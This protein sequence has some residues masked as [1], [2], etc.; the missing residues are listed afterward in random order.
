M[1]P[2]S[3]L[4]VT[5]AALIF[6][7]SVLAERHPASNGNATQQVVVVANIVGGGPLDLDQIQKYRSLLGDYPQNPKPVPSA[8]A[9]GCNG[10]A[11]ATGHV[12][13]QMYKWADVL[14]GLLPATPEALCSERCLSCAPGCDPICCTVSETSSSSSPCMAEGKTPKQGSETSPGNAPFGPPPPLPL[15]GCPCHCEASCPA[16]IQAI[17][18]VTPGSGAGKPAPDDGG[19]DGGNSTSPAKVQPPEQI[20]PNPADDQGS[21]PDSPQPL[22]L[23]GCPCHCEASCPANIQ[24]ICCVTPG[25]GAAKPAPDDGSSGSTPPASQADAQV[26]AEPP[27][28]TSLTPANHGTSSGATSGAGTGHDLFGLPQPLLGCPCHCEASCPPNIQAICCVTPGSGVAKPGPDP[29]DGN[30]DNNNKNSGWRDDTTPPPSQNQNNQKPLFDN[31]AKP[32]PNPK[33]RS[34]VGG[35]PNI[36]SAGQSPLLDCPCYCEASCP[37]NIQAVCCYTPGSGAAAAAGASSESDENEAKSKTGIDEDEG[38]A[39]ADADAE[40]DQNPPQSATLP[41]QYDDAVTLVTQTSTG[42]PVSVLAGINLTIFDSFVT[43]D[44]VNG[45]QRGEEIIFNT[46]SRTFEIVLNIVAVL[47]SGDGGS[48]AG[49]G[50]DDQ[51]DSAGI[52]TLGQTEQRCLKQSFRVIDGSGLWER[53]QVMLGLGAAARMGVLGVKKEGLNRVAL[54]VPILTGTKRVVVH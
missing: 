9:S 42:H 23:L 47:A 5:T 12:L 16:N 48:V 31:N 39:D 25:S 26:Q 21:E 13:D 14:N 27:K 28:Q 30:N 54:G 53:D 33:P 38:R 46:D 1:G 2:A 4:K 11:S 17:C 49:G 24:A 10:A 51:L 19:G 36:P 29:E 34:N 6:S 7:T 8:S 52:L 18:C 41:T 32:H 43:M 22:P 3:L 44:L 45:L 37:A 50:S 20:D 15:L 40:V 35:R